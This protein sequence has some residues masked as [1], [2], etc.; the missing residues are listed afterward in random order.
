MEW[1]IRSKG[2]K[3]DPCTVCGKPKTVRAI[4][5]ELAGCS[6]TEHFAICEDLCELNDLTVGVVDAK[7][8][9]KPSSKHLPDE[10]EEV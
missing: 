4:S 7:L 9:Y 3:T 1:P 5:Q 2:L 8:P 6:W 10:K